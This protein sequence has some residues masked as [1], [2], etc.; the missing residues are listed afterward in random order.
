ML[1][2][3]RSC[4]VVGLEGSLIEVEVDITNG[5]HMFT[6]VGLPDAAVNEAKERV[7]SAIKNSGCIFPYKHITIN[8]APAD[9]R[10]EGPAYDLPIAIGI[11]LASQDSVSGDFPVQNA[12]FLGELSLDGAV[13]H[14]NGILPMVALA[15][16]KQI[17]DVYVPAV[18]AQEAALVEGISVYPVETLAQLVAHINGQQQLVP[19][20]RDLS[21]LERANDVMYEQDMGA[22]RGQEH[23]KR[24]LEVAASGGHNILMSGPPGSGKTLLA[25][26]TASI[27]PVMRIEDALEVTKI[28]SVSGMLSSDVPLI[29]QRPFRSPHHTTSHAGLVGGGRMPRPG[30]IS[31]AHRGVLFLDELP[32]FGPRVLEVLRQPLEDKVVTISRAQGT[33]TFPANFMLVAAMNPC[34]C[35]F[36]AD[37]VRECTCSAVA[38]ARYQ[39]RIS[40]PLL[41]RI[42]IHVEVPRVD[43]E[44]L[45]DKR[46]VENSARIRARVQV[47]RE[48]QLQRFA[49]TKL[50]CNA[51]MGPAEVR[52]CCEVEATA[53]KLLKAAMQQ[54]HLS[55]RAFHRV[56]KLARTIAD[57]SDSEIIAAN[58]VAEAIQYRPR[59]GT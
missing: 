39:K 24:A 9:L 23:V 29:L 19:F 50:A 56:L 25:R 13:R 1:A 22:V 27:L 55:A 8:M 32:E 59:L 33:V 41:D 30:E 3:V 21:L 48:R 4:A 36:Y 42:D 44:K 2:M 40:G 28:Y 11:L 46:Q 57:L 15:R 35:G 10:K 5:M 20:V 16:E 18:D 54:L 47:A 7:R 31:L 26:A 45:A 38:I 6:I 14:T 51:E 43:Y 34:P 52:D 49:G 12:L 58:H 17:K 37:P 53:E